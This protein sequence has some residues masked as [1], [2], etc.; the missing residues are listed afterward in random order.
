MKN[1]SISIFYNVFYVGNIRMYLLDVRGK[2]EKLS[3]QIGRFTL[4]T[5]S[6]NFTTIPLTSIT[7][8]SMTHEAASSF[9]C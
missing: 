4:A 7:D 8:V 5:E 6:A 2:V 3:L 9:H 1:Y